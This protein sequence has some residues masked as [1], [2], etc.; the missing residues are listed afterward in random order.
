M[1]V[2]AQFARQA[3]A[4]EARHVLVGEHQIKALLLGFLEGVDAVD[5]LDHLEAGADQGEGNH[6][7]HGG[8]VVN[9]K[10]RVH[11][12]VP[13]SGV[14]WGCV[15]SRISGCAAAVFRTARPSRRPSR[16]A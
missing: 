4:V 2:L 5:G 15:A 3:D 8:R 16:F 13:W 6:L 9:G 14:G 11:G 7:A 12:E 1:R 10:D